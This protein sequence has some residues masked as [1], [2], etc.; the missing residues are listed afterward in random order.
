ML[1]KFTSQHI[2]QRYAMKTAETLL[3]LLF[4]CEVEFAKV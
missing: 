4:D 3:K 2:L 1:R